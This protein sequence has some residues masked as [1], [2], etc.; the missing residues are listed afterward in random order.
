MNPVLEPE[1]LMLDP[2]FVLS[3]EGAEWLEGDPEAL[4]GV[5]VPHAFMAWMQEGAPVEDML[6]FVAPEDRDGIEER[7]AGIWRRFQAA[8]VF[9]FE[10]A[11]LGDP[12]QEVLL[13]LRER[14]DLASLIAA[15]EWAY[16]QTHSWGL[17][18]LHLPLDAFRE[19]GA[20]VAEYGRR[21]RE[22]MVATVIPSRGGPPEI[23]RRV[24]GKTAAKWL[25]LGGAGAGGAALGAIGGM[26]IGS[27]AA[28]PAVRA[29]DP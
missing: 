13:A 19:A 9:S 22:E 25:I 12:E 18:K 16:L 23:T 2:S 8:R 1:L 24:L 17:S 14:G 26:A 15:D 7:R 27:G 3:R 28:I 6:A 10:E 5:V 4:S 29:F 21:L 20:A 11:Q